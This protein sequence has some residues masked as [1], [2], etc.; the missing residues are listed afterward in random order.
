MF[1]NDGSFMEMFKKKMEEE[2]RRKETEAT[3]RGGEGARSSEQ[4]QSQVDKK[5]AALT[6]FVRGLAV[7]R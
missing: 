5:P 2:K 1:A 3:G 7:V 6:S 4:G